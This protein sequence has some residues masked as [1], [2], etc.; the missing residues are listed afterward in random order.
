MRRRKSVSLH[1]ANDCH[2]AG[3]RHLMFATRVA[4]S[5][6]GRRALGIGDRVKVLEVE[7]FYPGT[8]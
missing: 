4:Q 6:R 1:R 2:E 7:N 8:L 5:A 3:Q